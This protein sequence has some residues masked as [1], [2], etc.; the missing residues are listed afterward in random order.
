M[1]SDTPTP[2]EGSKL[3]YVA[4][5]FEL[6]TPDLI[7]RGLSDGVVLTAP[8]IDNMRSI[9][10]SKYGYAGGVKAK[11]K[12]AK[13]KAAKKPNKPKSKAKPKAKASKPNAKAAAKHSNGVSPAR[14]LKQAQLRKLIFEMGFDDVRDIYLEFQDM[15]HRFEGS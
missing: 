13:P 12:P 14:A 6:P 15:H 1:P 9:L 4:K 3:E 8:R 10:R 5:H 11:A 7:T 2:K